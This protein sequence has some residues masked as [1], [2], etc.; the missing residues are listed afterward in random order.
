MLA[1][2]GCTDGTLAPPV[3]PAPPSAASSA[4]A[5]ASASSAPMTAKAPVLAPLD[6]DPVAVGLSEGGAT[7]L[8][9]E[10]LARASALLDEVR[11][12]ATAK[13]EALTWESTLGKLDAATLAVRSASDFPQLL[14]VAHPDKAVRD[15][16]K[17]CEPKVDKFST[18]LYL[19]PSLASVFK[20]F[21]ARKLPLSGPQARLL[22]HTLRDYRRNGLELPA[23]GQARLRALNEEITKLSQDFETNIAESTLFLEVTPKQL[24]GLPP[25][26]VDTHKPGPDGKIKIS[27]DYPDYFPFLQYAKDGAAALEMYKLFDNRAD[28]MKV[29]LLE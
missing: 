3:T 13:D 9:D 7:R 22:E 14:A 19:D 6:V 8:C 12:L 18:A 4:S 23:A 20:R 28:E 21:A 27:T 26:Y 11:A 29:P 2:A 24:E 25:S 17:A 15:A 1:L 5:P 16:A 10:S